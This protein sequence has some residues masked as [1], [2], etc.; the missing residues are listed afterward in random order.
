MYQPIVGEPPDYSLSAD[1]VPWVLGTQLTRQCGPVARTPG[2]SEILLIE[3]HD[4]AARMAYHHH[5]LT[6]V[7]SAMRQFRDRLRRE[8]YSV[9]YIQDDSFGDGLA[10]FFEDNP[11][12]TLVAMRSPSYGSERRFAELVDEAGG[13]VR[14]VENELFVST[15]QAFDKWA[16]GGPSEG[17]GPLNTSSSTAGCAGSP[18]Y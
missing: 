12:T 4:F 16:N 2:G 1:E 7:F 6:L 15:R 5:K 10:T 13:E 14:F 8:G 18:A 17:T 3:S 11:D 9:T